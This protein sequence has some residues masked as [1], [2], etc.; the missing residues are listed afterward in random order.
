[1][2]KGEV[3]KNLLAAEIDVLKGLRHAANV[4]ELYDVYNTK[5]NTYIV[6]ELCDGGDLAKLIQKNKTIPE[7][8]AIEYMRQI[9]IGY[10]NMHRHNIIHRDLKPANIFV[11]KG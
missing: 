8:E 6:T 4:I 7:P 9:I 1:M 10:S 5:N 3:H 11:K 2:L